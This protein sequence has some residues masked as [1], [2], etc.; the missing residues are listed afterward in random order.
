MNAIVA[1][2]FGLIVAAMSLAVF[3]VIGFAVLSDGLIP[4]N[5]PVDRSIAITGAILGSIL[6]VLIVGALS[7]MIHS[8]ELA[9]EQVRLLKE[10]SFKLDN[11][12]IGSDD[13]DK[14]EPSF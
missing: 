1:K 5:P 11:R 12:V 2:V 3:L 10:I 8:R 13:R 9:E 6:Y 4:Q 14:Q 7:V